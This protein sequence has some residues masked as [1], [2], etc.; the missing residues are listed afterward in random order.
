MGYWLVLYAIPGTNKV[1]FAI[2]SLQADK[3]LRQNIHL[4]LYTA[5]IK[6]SSSY[7][8]TPQYVFVKR[9]LLKRTHFIF[10]KYLYTFQSYTVNPDTSAVFLIVHFRPVN[11]NS[12]NMIK[13]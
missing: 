2:I 6:D 9:C 4:E 1:F 13:V 12:C 7:N 5:E 8:S 11:T 10:P 3:G